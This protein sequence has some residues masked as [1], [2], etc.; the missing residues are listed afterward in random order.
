MTDEQI[1]AIVEEIKRT[2]ELFIENYENKY[3]RKFL[4]G[5]LSV[6]INAIIEA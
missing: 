1:L 5:K 3:Y 6:L 4:I 2:A